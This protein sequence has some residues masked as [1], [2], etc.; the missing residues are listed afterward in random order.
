MFWGLEGFLFAVGHYES[1]G[2]SNFSETW[3]PLE[4]LDQ[5][6]IWLTGAV[7]QLRVCT[8]PF[9]IQWEWQGVIVFYLFFTLTQS[10]SSGFL[11]SWFSH[12]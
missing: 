3:V 5:S 12:Q 1:S 4:A 2:K 9:G 8:P 10:G 6:L 11:P 7:L